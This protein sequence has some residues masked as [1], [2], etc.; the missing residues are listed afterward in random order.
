MAGGRFTPPGRP[1]VYCASHRSLAVLEVAVHLDETARAKSWSLVG[2]DIP[3]DEIRIVA[4]EPEDLGR[5]WRATP[6]PSALQALGGMWLERELSAVL[7]VPSV[8]VSGEW[9]FL[10]NPL[11]AEF[12]R[13]EVQEA[14]DFDFD[15]RLLKD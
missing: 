11:H 14:I 2:A 4:L 12:S 6:A 15:P 9:N 7:R 13:I 5:N 10:L 3:E 1:A 8:L